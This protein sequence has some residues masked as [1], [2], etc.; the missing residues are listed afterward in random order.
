MVT[1]LEVFKPWGH[2]LDVELEFT[3][4]EAVISPAFSPTHSLRDLNILP[5]LLPN[6][7]KVNGMPMP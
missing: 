2:G 7:D 3:D 5:I 6:D 4:N 1:R